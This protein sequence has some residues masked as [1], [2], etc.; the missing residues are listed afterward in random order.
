MVKKTRK[1]KRGGA[2]NLMTPVPDTDYILFDIESIKDVPHP[3]KKVLNTLDELL[4]VEGFSE[5][6]ITEIKPANVG[7]KYLLFVI[8]GNTILCTVTFIIN[9]SESN[10]GYIDFVSCESKS[11]KYKPSSYLAVYQV[12]KILEHF[13]ITYCYLYVLP[14]EDRYW[15]L[16]NFYATIGFCCLPYQ[17]PD[18]TIR[19]VVKLS[20]NARNAFFEAHKA[21]NTF[22]RNHINVEHSVEN[23]TEYVYNC[24]HMIG[25][26]AEMV[27]KVKTVLNIH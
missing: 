11:G 18:K 3:I 9:E 27:E 26:V 16:Y 24:Y 15:K 2:F 13:K 17:I 19:N 23:A 20:A 4:A 5:L 14:E 12:F 22:L 8:E 10:I 7:H 1:S 6:H 25:K 21:T